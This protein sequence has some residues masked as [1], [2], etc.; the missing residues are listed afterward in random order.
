I[1]LDVDIGRLP[2]VEL[3]DVRAGAITA[4]DKRRA[5]LLDGLERRNNVLATVD[6]GGIALLSDQY[7]VVVH[8]P[9]ALYADAIGDEFLLG[10]LGVDKYDVGV[11][12]TTG[13][14][15]LPG[16][17][18]EDLHIDA[19]LGFEQGQYVAEQARVLRRGR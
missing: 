11:P 8:Y 6:A 7:E 9:V 1:H 18:C 12:T 3:G 4:R 16:S 14:E 17:L 5:L 10:C 2:E 15:C 13:I 19:G